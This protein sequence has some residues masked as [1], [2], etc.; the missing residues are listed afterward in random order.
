MKKRTCGGLGGSPC[1]ACQLINDAKIQAELSKLDIKDVV[2]KLIE[3]GWKK[4]F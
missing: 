3:V 1:V 2:D 4:V